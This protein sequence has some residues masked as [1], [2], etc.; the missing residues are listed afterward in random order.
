M[1]HRVREKTKI[2]QT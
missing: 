1:H 2:R